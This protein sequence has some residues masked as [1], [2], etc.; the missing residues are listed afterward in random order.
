MAKRMK[1]RC[2]Q[3][4]KSFRLK[5]HSYWQ[6]TAERFFSLCKSCHRKIIPWTM[7]SRTALRRREG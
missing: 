3:C 4:S 7:R 2:E 1:K 5:Y 6:W